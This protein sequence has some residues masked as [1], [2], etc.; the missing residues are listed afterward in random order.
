MSFS[1]IPR[2]LQAARFSGTSSARSDA[3]AQGLP[4]FTSVPVSSVQ[5][6]DRF[7]MVVSDIDGTLRTFNPENRFDSFSDAVKQTVRQLVQSGK[8]VV[9]A[10]GGRMSRIGAVLDIM[11]LRGQPTYFLSGDGSLIYNERGEKLKES[12][13]SP[14]ETQQLLDKLL[15]LLVRYDLQGHARLSIQ[16]NYYGLLHTATNTDQIPE[17][18]G[19]THNPISKKP[20]RLIHNQW[21]TNNPP[22]WLRPQKI[23]LMAQNPTVIQAV[24]QHITQQMPQVVTKLKTNG[25]LDI[26]PS[27]TSKAAAL[28]WL[29]ER[30][31]IPLQQVF[32]IGDG[33][34]DTELFEQVK[35]AGGMTVAMGNSPASL[36]AVAN[37]TTEAVEQDGFPN[38]IRRWVL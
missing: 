22:D 28:Q 35:A 10:S 17:L 32:A 33:E 3:A 36:K 29:S 9:F 27:Q 24:R 15:P 25:A 38:A 19:L 13:F 26:L 34:N 12:A 14:A 21:P 2:G 7:S 31:N 11:N 20:L 18:Q 37:H 5:K 23:T 4:A 16:G 1:F 30:L 6:T 8:L